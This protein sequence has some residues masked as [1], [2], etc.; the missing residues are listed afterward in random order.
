MQTSVFPLPIQGY[1]MCKH[2]YML[3]VGAVTNIERL[4]DMWSK[5]ST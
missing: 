2:S 1:Q 4:F 3:P 5:A